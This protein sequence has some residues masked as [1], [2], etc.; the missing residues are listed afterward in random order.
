M[1]NLALAPSSENG[2][3]VEDKMRRFKGECA[4]FSFNKCSIYAHDGAS[5]K[6]STYS[7]ESN[8]SV[9]GDSI[10]KAKVNRWGQVINEEKQ[11]EM[12]K[13]TAHYYTKKEWKNRICVGDL[14]TIYRIITAGNSWK[15]P[16]DRLKERLRR[17]QKVG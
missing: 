8:N 11:T 12:Q 1:L 2:T 9:G 13:G 17:C 5:A 15:M 7:H 16:N 14:R 6:L 10:Q 4:H 3:L